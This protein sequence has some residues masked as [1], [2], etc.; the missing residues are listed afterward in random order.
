MSFLSLVLPCMVHKKYTVK[1][2]RILF[3]KNLLEIFPD[4][5]GAPLRRIGYKEKM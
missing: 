1:V 3:R 4:S 5:R 2:K